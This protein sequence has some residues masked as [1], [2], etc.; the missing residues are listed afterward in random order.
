MM[1]ATAI[2][3]SLENKHVR[4]CDYFAIIPSGSHFKMLA[5]SFPTGLV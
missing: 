2:K 4:N 3:T 1:T 5:K